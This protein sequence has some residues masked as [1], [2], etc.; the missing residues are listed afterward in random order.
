[1]KGLDDLPVLNKCVDVGASFPPHVF[2]FAFGGLEE[3][4]RA[5]TSWGPGVAWHLGSP[6]RHSQQ[7]NGGEGEGIFSV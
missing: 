7:G 6:S 3:G 4:F 2:Q 1:M 5:G